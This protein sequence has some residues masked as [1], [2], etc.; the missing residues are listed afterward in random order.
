ME[1][2]KKEKFVISS[3]FKDNLKFQKISI[4]KNIF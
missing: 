4:I 1:K 3:E 2:K